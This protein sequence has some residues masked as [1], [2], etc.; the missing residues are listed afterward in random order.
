MIKVV[1]IMVGGNFRQ[2]SLFSDGTIFNEDPINGTD[3][4]RITINEY[5][6]YTQLEKNFNDAFKLTHRYGTIRMKTLK[7]RLLP[8]S[9]HYIPSANSSNTI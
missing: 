7:G 3:F 9:L 5:G 6:F 8:G 2:Y 1:N 4:Q